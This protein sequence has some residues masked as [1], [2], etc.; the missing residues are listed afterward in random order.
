MEVKKVRIKSELIKLGTTFEKTVK[1]LGI[2][3]KTEPCLFRK[4]PA[5]CS[6]YCIGTYFY[7]FVFAKVPSGEVQLVWIYVNA[8]Y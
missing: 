4:K 6:V 7:M 2:P 3:Y 8:G 1:S 5:F